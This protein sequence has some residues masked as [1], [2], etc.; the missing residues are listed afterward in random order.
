MPP[1]KPKVF[2]CYA[3]ADHD[4]VEVLYEK[5]SEAGFTPWMA[6]KNIMPGEKWRRTLFKAIREAPF[7]L[8]CL[9]NNSVDRRGVIQAE[10]KLALSMWREKLESDIYF[11]PV[12]LEKCEVQRL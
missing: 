5:L 12:R 6:P 3:H 10:I 4:R 1:E 2:L 9:S 11:I 8:A 7:F